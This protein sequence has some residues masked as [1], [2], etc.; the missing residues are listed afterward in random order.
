MLA[1]IYL[2]AGLTLAVM[3]V[4]SIARH[5]GDQSG[6]H[7]SMTTALLG[8]CLWVVVA[9]TLRVLPHFM[10]RPSHLLYMP[11]YT[12]LQYHLAL[13]KLYCLFTLH[14]TEWG[15]RQTDPIPTPENSTTLV[16]SDPP[17]RAR[18]DPVAA[19]GITA[20]NT[21]DVGIATQHPSPLCERT[22]RDCSSDSMNCN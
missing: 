9:R 10:S 17:S 2:L 22:Q 11:L 13:M 14:V 4:S 18:E 15:T 8:Y 1:P 5:C 12:L 21:E 20:S 6:W 19:V 3:V 16:S 7:I